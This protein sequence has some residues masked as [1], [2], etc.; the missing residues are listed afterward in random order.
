MD[1]LISAKPI[2]LTFATIIAICIGS[3]LNVVIL[4]LPKILEDQYQREAQELPGVNN[5]ESL[6]TQQHE[7]IHRSSACPNCHT[8]LKAWHNIPVLSFIFL[9]GKCAFCQ[10]KISPI[11]PIIEILT[12]AL[13]LLILWFFGINAF[14]LLLCVLCFFL[15]PLVAI[16]LKH[17][18]LPDVLTLPLLWLGLLANC[19]FFF[20]TPTMAILGASAGYGILWLV[21]WVFK[22]ITQKEGMGYGDFKLMAALG[23]W[24][25]IQSLLFLIFV[26]ALSGIVFALCASLIRKQQHNLIPFGP[27]IALTGILYPFIGQA[28]TATYFQVTLALF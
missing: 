5:G 8:A 11:Y 7:N 18:M 23:A 25:G 13:I 6:A 28:I 14:S 17:F 26:S 12:G 2:L 22:W 27:A 20:T 10:H 21:F 19:A 4:R 16:D 9:R 24:F 15:I 3:F 1:L